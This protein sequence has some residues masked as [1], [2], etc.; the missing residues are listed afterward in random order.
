MLDRG[1]F[2]KV[3]RDMLSLRCLSI[4]QSF[5]YAQSSQVCIIS[6]SVED[7]EKLADICLEMFFFS[8]NKKNHQQFT[9]FK[10]SH[11]LLQSLESFKQ[12]N[13]VH[14]FKISYDSIIMKFFI[15][16]TCPFHHELLLH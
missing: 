2:G 11:T 3:Y 9:S 14:I 13:I 8:S 12:I 6:S 5:F 1:M 4:N 16:K 10:D 7:R 15:I